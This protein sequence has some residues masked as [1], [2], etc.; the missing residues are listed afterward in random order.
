MYDSDLEREVVGETSGNFKR[1]TIS[2]LQGNRHEGEEV[3]LVL[4]KEDAMVN[5]CRFE[6][7][8]TSIRDV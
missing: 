7:A 8:M 6:D 4:A 3:D 5:I 1:L 2:L